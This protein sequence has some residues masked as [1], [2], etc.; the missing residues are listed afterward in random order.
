MDIDHMLDGIISQEHHKE[1]IQQAEH[2]R[3][4]QEAK[5]A[6]QHDEQAQGKVA[7]RTIKQ[8][9]L[10]TAQLLVK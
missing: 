4:V 8:L 2:H 5:L 9:V 1:L 6:S 10:A 3:L 7:Q